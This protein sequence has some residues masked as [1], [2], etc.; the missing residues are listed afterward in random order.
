M[1]FVRLSSDASV[2]CHYLYH[3]ANTVSPFAY[4]I[5]RYFIREFL[6]CDVF[7]FKEIIF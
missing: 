7:H 5:I 2:L 1:I 6:F 3:L 4:W